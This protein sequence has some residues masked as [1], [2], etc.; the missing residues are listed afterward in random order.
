[1]CESGVCE[2]VTWTHERACTSGRAC[3]RGYVHY[4]NGVQQLGNEEQEVKWVKWTRVVRGWGRE[5][6]GEMGEQK[7]VGKYLVL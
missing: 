3:V 2:Y 4:Y 1:M 5:D 7:G 6:E